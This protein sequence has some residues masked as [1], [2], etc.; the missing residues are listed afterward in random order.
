MFW[1]FLFVVAAVVADLF[2]WPTQAVLV[3]A[4]FALFL[5]FDDLDGGIG[6]DAAIR[7]L[8]RTRKAVGERK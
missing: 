1:G 5:L 3:V 4:V 6:H 2:G 7:Y 8:H